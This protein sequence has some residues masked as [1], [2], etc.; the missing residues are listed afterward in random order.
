MNLTDADSSR[1][2]FARNVCRAFSIDVPIQTF[3]G[4][5]CPWGA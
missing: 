2:M 5:R 4:E 3:S 1:R